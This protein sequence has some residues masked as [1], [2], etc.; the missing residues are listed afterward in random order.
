MAMNSATLA[1]AMKSAILSAIAPWENPS[2]DDHRLTGLT[3]DA[4]WTA[5]T[6]A[7]S[8]TVVNHIQSNAKATGLDSRGD[9]HTLDVA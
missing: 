1:A 6:N 9:N 4:Y 3:A 7:I 5:V 2:E 8:T